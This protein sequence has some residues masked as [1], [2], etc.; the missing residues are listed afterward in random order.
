VALGAAAVFAFAPYALFMSGSHMNHVT[1]LTWLLVGCTGVVRWVEA[2]SP[3]IGWALL[4]GLGFGIAATI[5]PLDAL[6]F[7]LPAGMWLVIRTVRRGGW[8]MLLASSAA[9]AAVLS[10][11]LWINAQTTGA[12]LLFGYNANY[13]AGQEI[14]FHRTPWGDVHTPAHGIELLN[15]YFVRLQSFFLEVPVPALFP[16]AAA[17]A[18]TRRLTPFDRYLLASSGLLCALYFAYWHDGFYLGPRFLYPMLPVLALWTARMFPAVRERVSSE[19]A[20]PTLALATVLAVGIGLTTSIPVRVREHRTRFTTMRWN[21][22]RA[23]SAAGIRHALVLVRESWG[24]Q[25]ISRM[26][27]AGFS[28]GRTEQ[29]YRRVDACLLEQALDTIEARRLE[30]AA[31][32]AVLLPLLADS[33]RV[34][35]SPYTVDKTNRYLA[36]VSYTPE[37]RRRLE[38]DH[39]GFT[40]YPPLVLAGRGDV[41]YAR[42][43]H[44]R[45]SL[46]LRTSPD[47]DV[48]LLRPASSTLGAQP[49]FERLDRDSLMSAWRHDH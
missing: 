29:I 32:E 35:P 23:A 38:D 1:A 8:A 43:L 20:G 10:V 24:A 9:L 18:L 17:L 48:Y 14:G 25:L 33:A 26:G 44:S 15:L 34:V 11:Q 28:A 37:C 47:R 12:A 41:I 36:G 30:R 16:A 46:L 45:D 22:D 21:A 4:T 27:A 13:G 7:A 31:A 42:D 40:L 3:H 39:R 5:R 2:E 6:T 19:L 49:A